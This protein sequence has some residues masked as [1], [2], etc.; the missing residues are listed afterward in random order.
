MKHVLVAVLALAVSAPV[1]SIPTSSEAQV[2]TGRGA[3]L[4]R[5]PRPALTERE[6]DRLYA[7]EDLVMEMDNQIAAIQQ[8]GEDQGGL[9]EEQRRE[10]AALT[11]RR[12]EAQR[13]ID[14]LEAKRNR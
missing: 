4:R 3:A 1:V 5:P 9:S 6:L 12:D 8:A 10:I 2:R 7:A 11:A 14:R 13:T